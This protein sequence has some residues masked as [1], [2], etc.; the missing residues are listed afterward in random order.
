M[1]FVYVQNPTG[2]IFSGDRLRTEID[3]GEGTAVHLTTPAA[4]KIAPVTGDGEA[5][6]KLVFRLGCNAFVEHVPEALIPFVG[7]VYVQDTYVQ[8]SN[9]SSFIGV[10]RVAPGRVARGEDF[11]YERLE[12]RTVVHSADGQELCHDRL[13]LEPARMSPSRRGLLGLRPYLGMITVLA[14]D[15]DVDPIVA[16]M[17]DAVKPYGAAA[18]LPSAAGIFARVLAPTSGALSAAVDAAWRVARGALRGNGLPPRR[19]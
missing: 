18:S 3:A 17:D 5:Q 1:A 10:E 15:R 8:L 19:K 13:V 16:A 7:S 11:D 14:P 4:T 12:L 9:G 6:S 2:A